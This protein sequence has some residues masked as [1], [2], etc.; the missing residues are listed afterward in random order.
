MVFV[1]ASSNFVTLTITPFL[2]DRTEGDETV[3]LTVLP[4]LA[5]TIG[6]T[7]A[8]IT[9]HDSPY[10]VWSVAHFTLE[11]LTDPTLSSEAADFDDDASAFF[12]AEDSARYSIN[13][14]GA[15][16]WWWIQPSNASCLRQQFMN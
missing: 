11:E 16:K 9:I 6:N 7:N 14:A 15:G 13:T 2:D 10:G 3:T 4:A 8:T 12:C 5:Y 1:P